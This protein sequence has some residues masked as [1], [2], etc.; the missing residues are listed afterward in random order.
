MNSQRVAVVVGR[1]A[2]SITYILE[3]FL[4][5]DCEQEPRHSVVG[6]GCHG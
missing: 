4:P 3:T 2:V 5:Q 6:V 1:R